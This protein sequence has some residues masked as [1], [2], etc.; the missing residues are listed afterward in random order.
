[1]EKFDRRDVRFV[2]LVALAIALGA[3]VTA[4]LF[5]RAFPEASI[6]FRVNRGQARA[7]AER[8]LQERGRKVAGHRFA[9]RFSVDEEPKVYLER[10]LG[11]E[12]AGQFY[13]DEAKVWRWDMR[14]FR[15]GVK[16]EEHLSITPR[17]E[18]VSFQSV[19]REDAPG[20]RLSREAARE[21]ASRFLASRGFRSSET[22]EIEATPVS[23]PARTDWKFVDEKVGFRM[24]EATLRYATTVAGGEVTGFREFV[25]VPESWKRDYQALRAKNEA[26]GTV[27]T[28]GLYVTM[29]ALLGVLI[30]KIVRKD[31]LWKVV[32]AFGLIAFVLA[33]LSDINALPLT[34]Y[35]YDT[36][37]PLSSFMTS[38]LVFA[39]LSALAVGALIAVV[40]AGA[41]PIYRERF[42]RHLSLSGMFSRRGIQTKSFFKGVLLGYALT[43]FF[44]AYQAVFYVIAA[45]F[46][47]WAPA[48]IPYSDMLNTAFP[49][50]TVL[51]IGFLPAVS[52]EGISRM[53]SISFLDRIGAGRFVAIVLPAVIWG[54]GHAAYPN[55]PFYIRGVEVGL[56][57]ILIGL[58]MVRFGVLPL[59]VWHFTVD[60]I[61]TALLMLR[62]GNTY[63]VVSGAI[64]SGILLLPLAVS[65]ILYAR[66]GGFAAADGLTNGDLGFVPAPPPA[67]AAV[68][69]IPEIRPLRRGALAAMTAAA[70]VLGTSLLL[71]GHPADPLVED[72][73]GRRRAE[74][75]G[76]AFLRAN[77]VAS[78]DYQMVS[79]LGTGCPDDEAVRAEKP[80][81]EGRIPG[82]SEAGARYVIREGGIGALEKLSVDKLPLSYWVIRFLKPGVKEEWKVLVDAERRR[83][84]AFVNP[85][86]EKA[87]AGPPVSSARA[88]ERALSAAAA[89]GYSA[90]DYRVLDV[91]TRARPARVDTTVV[92]EARPPGIGDARPRLT[93]VFHG[94]R[95]AAFYPSLRVPEGFLRQ[96]RKR[97]A[98]EWILIAVRIVAFGALIGVAVVLFIRAVKRPDFRWRALIPP[99]I[100]VA[101]FAGLALANSA[102]AAMRQYQTEIPLSA[103][104]LSV[105]VGLLIVWI[106]LIV[107][108]AVGFVLFFAARPGWRRALRLGSL[109]DG[110]LRAAVAAL[111]LAG[112][113]Q[114]SDVIS[115]RF[116]A[117][118]DPDPSLPQALE[119]AVPGFA[120]LWSVSTATFALAGFAAVVALAAQRELLKKPI[121]RALGA[122]ALLFAIAP[123]SFRSTGEFLA[124]FLPGI[125]VAAWVILCAFLVLRDHPGAWV[126]FGALAYG[127][128]AV[129]ELLSQPAAEDRLAG[130]TA[131]ALI[132]VT[133]AI[134]LWRKRPRALAVE[135]ELA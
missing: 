11:L 20:E 80:E 37:D 39:V 109:S 125:L 22:K 68:E 17:G 121:G 94:P 85:K 41:E 118:Y 10:E 108:A 8:L 115:A 114:W 29:L 95:L 69:T 78:E 79:Y 64:A 87:P 40:V 2:I 71:P 35:D 19:L 117:L 38:R 91:G 67:P 113:T 26:A 23:R 89:L 124:D 9:G 24:G 75:L 100:Y 52:E 93:A 30:T 1:M 42:P 21:R 127:S 133:V 25:Y 7:I 61:Y 119:R 111:G 3:A 131:L 13:G 34:L 130:W 5:R 116:P 46:G 18:L 77:G 135:P 92:L 63:Y 122:V 129:L 33:L 15:S 47:A 83:V 65:L 86:E 97:L 6:E 99:L 53:F 107:A 59:L 126:I 98:I 112:L 106:G 55:Q 120:A 43:A 84:A 81:E 50:A 132:A 44:F 58:L 82:F 32:A 110:F 70:V 74:F 66:R 123:T 102:G 60:A 49:W 16:E 73:T 56:A 128:R 12:R 101:I 31:V 62:S 134:L 54:F 90:K 57:G 4:A 96:F 105:A 104:R 88:R 36:K 45:R 27:A 103:F 14:W 48:D 28:F 51:L 72:A 76:R